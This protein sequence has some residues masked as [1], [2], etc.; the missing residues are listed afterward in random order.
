MR[1]LKIYIDTSAFRIQDFKYIERSPIIAN[2]DY[3][4]DRATKWICYIARVLALIWAGWWTFFGLASGL[5]EGLSPVGVL[6]YAL[7]PGLVFLLSAVIAWRWETIGG[8]VLVL[9]GLFLFIWYPI[10]YSHFSPSL[11]I[12]VLSALAL[13]PLVAGFLFLASRWRSRKLGIL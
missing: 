1:K 10:R 6:R 7:L 13:P 9:E 5:H 2:I 3:T 11:I 4:G 8:I 12:S